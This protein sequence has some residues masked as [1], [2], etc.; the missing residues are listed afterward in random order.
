M[1]W[2]NHSTPPSGLSHFR[3]VGQTSGK[4]VVEPVQASSRRSRAARPA[5]DGLAGLVLRAALLREE[6]RGDHVRPTIRPR[7]PWGGLEVVAT[8]DQLMVRPRARASVTM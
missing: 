6:S 7:P 1:L 5:T 3:A 2:I 4:T 8:R